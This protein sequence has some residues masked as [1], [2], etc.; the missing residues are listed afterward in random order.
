MFFDMQLFGGDL[1]LR[2]RDLNLATGGGKEQDEGFS[3]EAFA[4][5]KKAEDGLRG[6][7]AG[8]DGELEWA[9]GNHGEVEASVAV[10]GCGEGGCGICC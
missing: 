5:V 7:A 9:G 10:S 8:G 1:G 3:F 2:G 4:G 6:K